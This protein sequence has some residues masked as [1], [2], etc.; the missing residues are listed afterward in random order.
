MVILK[1]QRQPTRNSHE[2]VSDSGA[3]S[4]DCLFEG[5]VRKLTQTG[6]CVL[7]TEKL[8]RLPDTQSCQD[9]QEV[10]LRPKIPSAAL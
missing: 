9:S 8:H 3:A 10:A 6:L 7:M 5:V 4:A 2:A 1:Q